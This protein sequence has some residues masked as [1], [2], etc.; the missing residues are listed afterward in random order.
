MMGENMEFS[1][2]NSIVVDI[3]YIFSYCFHLFLLT[4]H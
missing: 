2:I 3:F 4:K 1:A